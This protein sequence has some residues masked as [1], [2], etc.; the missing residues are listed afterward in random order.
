MEIDKLKAAF[1]GKGAKGGATEGANFK[2]KDFGE[3][4]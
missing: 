4:S 3:A 1:A 2:V